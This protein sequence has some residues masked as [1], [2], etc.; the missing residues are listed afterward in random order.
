MQIRLEGIVAYFLFIDESGQDHRASP[1]EVLAGVAVEDRDL[2]NLIKTIQDAEERNFGIRYSTGRSEL[3]G[4]KLLKAKVYKLAKQLPPIPDVERRGLARQC[5]IAGNIVGR[6]EIV[7]L[8]QAKLDYVAEVFEICARFRCKAFASIVSKDAPTPDSSEYLRKDYAY[9]FQRFF[10]FLE[11]ID[12]AMSGII[13]FDEFEKSRSH[14]LVEQMDRY[15]KRTAK[16]QQRSGQIIPEPFFV[17]SD[18]TTGIQVADLIAY[19]LSW[20][21]RT[22]EMKEPARGELA[23]LVNQIRLMRHRAVRDIANNPNFTIWS[24][25]N[26][27]TDLRPAGLQDSD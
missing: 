9:L 5:L 4:K 8:A 26:L 25:T 2:W 14:L 3:K 24:F 16:G 17:H 27:I 18:L 11:D 15:F 19:I 20:G 6:R 22:K 7:A 1:Y 21:F 23:D 12:P 10:Y 13:V